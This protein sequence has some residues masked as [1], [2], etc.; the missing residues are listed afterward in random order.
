MTLWQ[1]RRTGAL[2]RLP[3]AATPDAGCQSAKRA[4]SIL[5]TCCLM[6]AEGVNHK[7]PAPVPNTDR[8]LLEN[9]TK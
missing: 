1:V 3:G 9:D 8:F 6:V 2:P 4:L 7:E 5:H